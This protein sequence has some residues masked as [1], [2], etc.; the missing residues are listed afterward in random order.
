MK[1][2]DFLYILQENLLFFGTVT[3][4]VSIGRNMINILGYVGVRF[5]NFLE[6]IGSMG[7]FLFRVVFQGIRKG[8][9]GREVMTHLFSMGF[10]SVSLVSLTALF[11]GMVL[12]LQT[13]TAFEHMSVESVLPEIVALSIVR[14]LG[15]VLTGLMMAGRLGASMAS[16]IATMRVTE[17]IDALVALSTNPLQYLV[18]PRI[19]SAIIILPILTLL[20]DIIGIAGGYWV[21]IFHCGF[22]SEQYMTQTFDALKYADVFSG[23]VKAGFFGFFLSFISCHEGYYAQNGASGVGK[24]TTNGVVRSCIVILLINYLLTALFF[25]R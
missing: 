10:S 1:V 4:Q 23:L 2:D 12:A 19:V 17:Q 3:V 24:S 21:S 25:S 8:F 7:F 22:H 16:E 6:A 20:A 18:V 5:L 9:S 11:T 13:Y 15:P 14:E